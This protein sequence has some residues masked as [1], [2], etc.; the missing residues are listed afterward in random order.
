MALVSESMNRRLV[1][2]SPQASMAE[3]VSVVQRAGVEH[4]L[5]TDEDTLVGILCACELRN[6]RL[7]DRVCDRMSRAPATVRPDVPVE[8]AVA[9]LAAYEA[10]CLPVAVGGLILGTLS[11]AEL[12]RAGVGEP[13][14]HCRRM[15]RRRA[16]RIRA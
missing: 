10:G 12:I 13:R 14:P 4:V 8:D 9:T 1:A 15:H 11:E 16:P 3:A 6:G 5:V 7:D 2:V